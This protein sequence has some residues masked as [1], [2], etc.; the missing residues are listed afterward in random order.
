MRVAAAGRVWHI[1]SQQKRNIVMRILGCGR[2][3]KDVVMTVF[4]VGSFVNE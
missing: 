3:F 2:I 4:E 1:V